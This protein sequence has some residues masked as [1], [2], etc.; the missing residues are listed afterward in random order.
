MLFDVCLLNRRI[1]SMLL[2]ISLA[3]LLKRYGTQA[4]P[5]PAP[6]PTSA[7]LGT[8]LVAREGPLD[9]CHARTVLDILWSC[10]ATTFACSWVSVHP[11]VPWHNEGKWTI[12]RRR[13]FLMLFSMLAPEFMVM[14]AFKQWRGA[15]MIREAVNK[16]LK[17][18]SPNTR[19][20]DYNF[21][22]V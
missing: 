10:L 22:L 21:Q 16:A 15:V 2:L 3:V 7:T 12:L 18:A 19:T 8:H 11:N 5:L 20:H 9:G 1:L 4:I 13:I 14:W 6:T 17:D